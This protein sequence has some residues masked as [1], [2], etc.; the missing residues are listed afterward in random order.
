MAGA[1]GLLG[2][3][4]S[5]NLAQNLP[6][7]ASRF[8]TWATYWYLTTKVIIQRKKPTDDGGF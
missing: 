4:I 3:H 2:A 8:F 1:S 6:T 7:V 5:R